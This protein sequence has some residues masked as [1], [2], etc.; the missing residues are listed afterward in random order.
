MKTKLFIGSTLAAVLLLSAIFSQPAAA[1]SKPVSCKVSK[2]NA[3]FFVRA[4]EKFIKLNKGTL[5]SWT[6]FDM[7]QGLIVVKAK[8]G[9][10]WIQGE[11]LMDDTTCN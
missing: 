3:K 11:I 2:N 1:Q 4:T 6:I 8:V 10:K 9:K 7:Q 5:L